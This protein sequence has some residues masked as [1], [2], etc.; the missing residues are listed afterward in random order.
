MTNDLLK[1]KADKVKRGKG[2]ACVLRQLNNF[3]F[4][5]AQVQVFVLSIAYCRTSEL[6]LS[7][8]TQR[9]F[10]LK[11]FQIVKHSTTYGSRF[12]CITNME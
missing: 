4:V 9:Y 5:K 8:E 11:P 6:S 7:K 1:I 3:L 2:V 12:T 10:K